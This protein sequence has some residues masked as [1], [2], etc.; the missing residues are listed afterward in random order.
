MDDIVVVLS[1]FDRKIGPTCFIEVP[2][3]NLNPELKMTL[4]QIF[5][6]TT[7]EG[8]FWHSL[9]GKYIT[10][11][12]YYFEIDS[13]WARGSKEMLMIS[14]LFSRKLESET[15]HQVL[16]WI[17]DFKQKLRV[18]RNIFKAFYY[19]IKKDYLAKKTDE[20]DENYKIVERWVKELYWATKEEIREKSD[21]EIIAEL[22]V[23][24]PIWK[25]IK[26]LSKYPLEYRSLEEWYNKQGFSREFT[27]IVSKLEKNK[28]IFINTINHQQYVLLV[29]DVR[30]L[31]IPPTCVMELY[32][33]REKLKPL[34]DYYIKIVGDFFD[35]Y[36]P[37]NED[38]Q[39][40]FSIIAQPR[41]YNLICELRKGP[42]IKS[43]ISSILRQGPFIA[44]NINILGNL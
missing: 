7:N 42:I 4:N 13:D 20:I 15:E 3:E 36:N 35:N 38:K 25:T 18:T 31:R 1:Y 10:S 6:Q 5:D 33:K 26:K 9:Q 40:L 28:F 11:L 34:V 14:I 39:R 32:D 8:F 27:K 16:S 29:K 44:T 19:N 12:N 30:I 2:S 23:V 17:I 41:Y 21:E 43:K 24:D 22:M 37:N